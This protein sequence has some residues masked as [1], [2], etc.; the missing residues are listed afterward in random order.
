MFL[1]LR[2]YTLVVQITFRSLVNS[3]RKSPSAQTNLTAWP[4]LKRSG[5]SRGLYTYPHQM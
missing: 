2:E 4:R 3:I 5:V 1:L